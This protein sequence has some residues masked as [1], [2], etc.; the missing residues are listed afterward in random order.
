MIFSSRDFV[1]VSRSEMQQSAASAIAGKMTRACDGC[2][3]RQARWYCSAD[4]VFLCQICDSSVHS[5]NPVA[6]RHQRLRLKPA[7][8]SYSSSDVEAKTEE[9][10]FGWLKRKA[11]TP[12]PHQQAKPAQPLVPDL[13]ENSPD[14]NCSEE[15]QLLYCVPV[16]DPMPAELCSPPCLNDWNSSDEDPKLV[17]AQ[18]P[19]NAITYTSPVDATGS[20]LVGFVPSDDELAEFAANM[21]SLLGKGLDNSENPSEHGTKAELDNGMEMATSRQSMKKGEKAVSRKKVALRLD[22]EAIMAA[23]SSSPWTNG[24]R[25]Q[26]NLDVCS[27]PDMGMWAGEGGEDKGGGR[28]ERESKVTRYREKRRTR[29]FAK[30]IRYEVRRL[31]AEK[32]PRMKGRFVKRASMAP[33]PAFA[34]PVLD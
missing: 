24:A 13:L 4:D 31:N 26:F 8:S 5:P 20:R 6:R 16:F 9:L 7:T 1:T 11:R 18:L 17:A 2:V 15:E 28:Q 23:W 29:L 32:R 3:R 19:D 22:Y 10:I 21:E 34:G 30:K 12:R 25:P 27:W 14:G 33:T